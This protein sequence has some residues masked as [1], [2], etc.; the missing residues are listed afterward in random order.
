M[1]KSLVVKKLP[2]AETGHQLP[3][4]LRL[5]IRFIRW[6]VYI[7]C[8]FVCQVVEWSV[9]AK[10]LKTCYM[11]GVADSLC[12]NYIR[13]MV[14]KSDNEFLICGT[15][16]YSPLCR[17][18]SQTTVSHSRHQDKSNLKVSSRWIVGSC[19]I[20]R[21]TMNAMNSFEILNLITLSQP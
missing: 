21:E 18:Y 14:R 15:N 8:W 5:Y 10:Q 20:S 12:Q 19:L 7:W 4:S 16:A 17:V 2:R 11:N 9:D 6:S 13:I 1:P 3:T